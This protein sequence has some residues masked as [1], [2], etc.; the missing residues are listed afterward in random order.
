MVATYPANYYRLQAGRRRR[1]SRDHGKALT[2]TMRAPPR[3]QSRHR[4]GRITREQRKQKQQETCRRQQKQQ[5]R[6]RYH[7]TQRNDLVLYATILLTATIGYIGY[8]KYNG[9]P[10]KPKSATEAQDMYQKMEEERRQ[11]NNNAVKE[12]Q[13][14]HQQEKGRKQ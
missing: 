2:S 11:R 10:L 13:Q 14:N 7:A 5:Q 12:P 6:R 3:V 4:Y 8:K 1:K 9:E